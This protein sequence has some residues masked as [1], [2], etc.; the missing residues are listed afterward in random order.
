MSRVLH[1]IIMSPER[2]TARRGYFGGS[3]APRLMAGDDA[4]VTAMWQVK[5]GEVEPDDLSDVLPVQMGSFTEDL[6]LDWFELTT[7]RVVTDEQREVFHPTVPFVRVTLDGMTTT[8]TG[9]VAII[10]AKHVN[11]FSKLADVVARYQPQVQLEMAATGTSWAILSVFIGTLRYEC[12]EIPADPAYQFDLLAAI[13]CFWDCVKSGDS[14][15]TVQVEAPKLPPEYR[16]VD[17]TG[18]N[19]WAAHAGRWL[20]NAGPAKAFA[21]AAKDI[22]EI[23]P[24]D[25]NTATGHGIAVIRSKSGSLTIKEMKDATT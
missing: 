9:D 22:K 13:E 16:D 4:A 12:V 8:A 18:Q 25:A 10:Q 6:N 11:A 17:M 7:S 23:T 15:V 1:K 5:R 3:D 2:V 24:D 14:P 21:A 20:A 19:E